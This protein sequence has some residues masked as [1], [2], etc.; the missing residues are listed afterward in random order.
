MKIKIR[1]IFLILFAFF[2]ELSV[3]NAWTDHFYGAYYSLVNVPEFKK[4]VTVES[5]E[6]FLAKEADKLAIE[7]VEIYRM[8]YLKR[9]SA[10]WRWWFDAL[11][12]ENAASSICVIAWIKLAEQR[13]YGHYF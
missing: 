8:W 5:L 2:I 10:D 7:L 9:D 3:V 6:S 4:Q 11:I 13:R 1:V 12:L